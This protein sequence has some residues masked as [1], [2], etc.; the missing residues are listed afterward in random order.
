MKLYELM[1]IFDGGLTSEKQKTLLELV[2]GFIAEVKGS[3]K[4]KTDLG[5]KEFAYQ[6]G[7][8]DYGF[9][10]LLEAELEE[11][12]VPV[13]DK[14]MRLEKGI[15]RHLVTS[16]GKSTKKPEAKPK[17][18]PK[19][20]KKTETQPKKKTAARKNTAKAKNKSKK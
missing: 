20:E 17:E 12:F 18:E 13:V 1:V 4:K 16:I 15:V 7:K 10:W 3:V 2:E 8:K 14:K 9:Y 5:K 6:I 11:E 19:A